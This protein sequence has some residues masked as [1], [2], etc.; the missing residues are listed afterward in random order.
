MGRQR[1]LRVFGASTITA[2][3]MGVGSIAAAMPARGSAHPARAPK[4]VA[5]AGRAWGL[6]PVVGRAS[7]GPFSSAPLLYHG[8]PVMR[9]V[10]VHTVFWAPSGFTFPPAPTAGAPSY[11][12]LLER[13]FTDAARSSGSGS[14][15][16]SVLDQYG[17]SSG[18]GSDAISYAP[19]PDVISDNDPYPPSSQCASPAGL[20]V[21]VSSAQIERELD[22]VVSRHDPGARG[23]HDLWVVLLP[24]DVDACVTGA[25]CGTTAFA[26]YHSQFDRGHGSTVYALVVNPLIEGVPPSGGDPEGNP[27]AE[28]AANVAA[29][30]TVEAASDPEGTGWIDP[31]GGEIGDKCQATNGAVLGYAANGAPYNQQLAGDPFLIQTMWSDLAAGCVAQ[32]APVSAPRLPGV[33]MGQFSALVR[34]NAAVARAAIPVRVKLLRAGTLV[35]RGQARTDARGDWAA[36][37]RSLGTGLAAP[38]GDDRD[39]LDISY[40]PGGPV[41]ESILPGQGGDP[42]DQAGYTGWSMLDSGFALGAGTVAIAPCSQ[43]GVLRVTVDGRAVADPVT[44]C[45]TGADVSRVPAG[46]LGPRALGSLSSTDNRAAGPGDPGGVLVRMTVAMGEPRSVATGPGTSSSLVATGFPSCTADLVRQTVTCTGLVPGA[47]YHLGGTAHALGARADQAGRARFAPR[48]GVAWLAGGDIV[49]L[50]NRVGRRLSTLHVA[51]LQVALSDTGAVTAGSCQPG[52]YW[53]APSPA[54]QPP[55]S[56]LAILQLTAPPAGSAPTI[57]PL[58]GRAAHLPGPAL[59]QTDGY[60]GGATTAEVPRFALINPANAASLYGPFIALAQFAAGPH[61]GASVSLQITR[62]GAVHPT[63]RLRDVSSRQ[64]VRVR[65]LPAGLYHA[66]WTIID[67]NRDTR[68]LH[69]TFVQEP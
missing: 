20:P 50:R 10:H 35:A 63:I 18:G 38:V 66:T 48:G 52:E 51:H 60:S 64:G 5:R 68:A 62:A 34:G 40:G 27:V 31:F 6:V 8:G 30:E 29:H 61:T 44:N 42:A 26:G 41:Q 45:Q 23:L 32:G 12:G 67:A 59:E 14:G 43:V 46:P 33:S 36:T 69:T 24:P 28:V 21:C 17:D 9:G 1:V 53:G 56:L 3:L 49:A 39:E 2:A 58:S 65:R 57:C 15:V 22:G 25:M 7:S 37:L 16:F 4:F 13:F 54:I 47:P 11:A 55:S 19:G